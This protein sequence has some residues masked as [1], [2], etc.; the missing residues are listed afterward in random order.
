MVVVAF[1]VVALG[2][3]FL[4]AAA[5]LAA[6]FLAAGFLAS[7]LGASFSLPAAF[8]ALAATLI[9]PETPLGRRR[10]PLSAPRLMA[11][12]RLLMFEADERSMLYFVARNFLMVGRETPER[13]SSG[14]ARIASCDESATVSSGEDHSRSEATSNRERWAVCPKTAI[15][16]GR[17]PRI[18]ATYA[19]KADTSC[20]AQARRYGASSGVLN[21]APRGRIASAL[22]PKGRLSQPPG[23]SSLSAA[24]GSVGAAQP[25]VSDPLPHNSMHHAERS[26][27]HAGAASRQSRLQLERSRLHGVRKCNTCCGCLVESLIWPGGVGSGVGVRTDLD[28]VEESGV[29]RRLLGGRAGSLLDGSHCC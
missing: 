16:S 8:L 28:H 27:T 4:G 23:R 11:L 18:A 12:E 9:L 5:F 29:R 17:S 20:V 10:T 6:G 7:F 1:L 24:W 2:A 3:V 19:S 15:E 22:A 26:V 25:V 21:D 13:A 14:W